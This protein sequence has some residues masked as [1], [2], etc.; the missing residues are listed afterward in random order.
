MWFVA[1]SSPGIKGEPLISIRKFPGLQIT[2][3]SLA[4]DS[5]WFPSGWPWPTQPSPPF[6]DGEHHA[7]DD[8]KANRTFPA[9]LV[10]DIHFDPFHDPARAQQ[11]VDAPVG[12]WSSI[13]SAPPSP[14][15]Q[16]AFAGLQ[17]TCH[18]RGVDTPYA[19][20]HSSLQAMRSQQPDAKFMTVSG[21]LIAHSF[22]C[23]Y[24]TLLPGSTQSDYQAFVLKT[25]SFVM[26]ELRAAF[27][28]VPVYVALG[29]ND[30]ACGDYR[31]DT[32]SDFL[33]QAGRI[34]AK[35]LP[36]SQQQ[37]AL[38]A[39]AKGGYYSLTMATAHAGY[40]PHRRQRHFSSPKYST[41][42]G[43]PDFAA[44]TAEMTWLQEQ[45][46]AG[47]A[48]GAKSL[49]HG[50]HSAGR[51]SVLDG[52][53]VQGCLRERGA[54]NVSILGQTGRSADRIWRRYP[55]RDLRSFPHG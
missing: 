45:L 25:L 46:A 30:T 41:C 22:S 53:K 37:Q 13:L 40:A 28:G 7:A 5:R 31:L 51:R 48:I 17:Q 54:G 11:L 50:S 23:R 27:P 1:V 18:A 55:A 24:T 15:Q 35:G 29:N 6:H 3:W 10:S 2:F 52:C 19:L 16:Q 47:A 20:L 14:N 4:P 34:V 26:G 43:R 12:Q 33:V 42:A 9:L 36:H 49:G 39:F 8:A 21:D 44:A 38:K 32:G